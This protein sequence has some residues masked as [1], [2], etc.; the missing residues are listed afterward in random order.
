MRIDHVLDAAVETEAGVEKVRGCSVRKRGAEIREHGPITKRCA[1]G[2][3][4][5]GLGA[6][7]DP[8]GGEVSIGEAYLTCDHHVEDTIGP[9][10]FIGKRSTYLLGHAPRRGPRWLQSGERA[11][12]LLQRPCRESKACGGCPGRIV[13]HACGI[14]YAPCICECLIEVDVALVQSAGHR[15]H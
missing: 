4:R 3:A 5:A 14:S 10:V 13:K 7:N 9:P 6:R 15:S 12:W 11:G 1:S 8:F 2:S